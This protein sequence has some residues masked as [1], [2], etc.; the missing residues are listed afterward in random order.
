MFFFMYCEFFIVRDRPI[1]VD[2]IKSTQL[3]ISTKFVPHIYLLVV[4][5][6]PRIYVSTEMQFSLKPRKLIFTN[7]N[8]LTV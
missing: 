7:L 3:K 6:Y 5:V 1:V 8:E 2:S 4:T